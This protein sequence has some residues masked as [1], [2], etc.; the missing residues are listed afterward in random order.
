MQCDA[1]GTQ[2]VILE[3]GRYYIHLDSKT[4]GDKAGA[5]LCVEPTPDGW[6]PPDPCRSNVRVD[7]WRTDRGSDWSVELRAGSAL[8]VW[9]KEGSFDARASTRCPAGAQVDTANFSGSGGFRASFV[10]TRH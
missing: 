4:M 6:R 9:I 8:A 3:P 10:V 1:S 7:E 2:Y 5:S